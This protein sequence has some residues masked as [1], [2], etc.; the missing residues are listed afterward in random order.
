MHVP[1][2]VDPWRAQRSRV[3]LASLDEVFDPSNGDPQRTG[4]FRV[5]VG[6]GLAVHQIAVSVV[7]P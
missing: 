2:H 1:I 4:T 5:E 6:G 7:L 3:D